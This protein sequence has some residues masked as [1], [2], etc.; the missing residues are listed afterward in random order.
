MIGTAETIHNPTPSTILRVCVSWYCS[1][2][3]RTIP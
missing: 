2:R 3:A 1:E